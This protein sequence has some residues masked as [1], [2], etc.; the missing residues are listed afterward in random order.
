MNL[1]GQW[2]GT[3]TYG[4]EYRLHKNK[5]L[6]FDMELFQEREKI[7]GTAVDVDGVGMSPD[8]AMIH[9]NFKDNTISFIKKYASRHYS[10][11]G[12]TKVDNSRL[13]PDIHYSGDYNEHQQR[14]EGIWTIRSRG[15]FLGFIPLKY[16]LTGTWLMRRK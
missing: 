11:G 6:Y 4:K 1:Q 15:W 9:G 16:T 14:F 2:T 8:R 5:Q 10:V 12:E 7:T 3:I 13:G